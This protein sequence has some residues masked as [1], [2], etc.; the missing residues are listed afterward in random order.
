[1]KYIEELSPGD[2]FSFQDNKFLLTADF[3]MNSK[4]CVRMCIS[5]KDGCSRWMDS[6]EI[7]EYC[8]LFYRDKENNILSI[9]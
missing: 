2:I 7:T 9:K 5:I 4:K 1:M 3:K 8:E 6:D